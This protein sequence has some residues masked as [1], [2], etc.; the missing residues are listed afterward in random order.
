MV[1]DQKHGAS[2]V[3]SYNRMYRFLMRIVQS[4][5]A[6]SRVINKNWTIGLKSSLKESSYF[7]FYMIFKIHCKTIPTLITLIHENCLD[8]NT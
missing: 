7:T 8:K 3:K 1:V 6:N 2:Q 4:K 5:V